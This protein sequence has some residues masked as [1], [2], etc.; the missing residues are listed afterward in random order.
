MKD[1]APPLSRARIRSI[2]LTDALIVAEWLNAAAGTKARTR[3]LAFRTHLEYL[4]K[5]ADS[6]RTGEPEFRL[7]LNEVN[8]RLSRYSFHS[9]LS[10]DSG[11]WRDNAVAKDAR[12]RTVEVT[13]QGVTVEVNEAAAVAAL[14]RLHARGQLG[15]VRMCEWCKENFRVSERELD[16]F[17]SDRCRNADYQARPATVDRKK[18]AQKRWRDKESGENAKALA[19]VRAPLKGRK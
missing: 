15:K 12:G 2:A 14:G 18:K 4:T 17:C 5:M 8:N 10:Y 16:R 7:R 9:L 11:M 3:V 13:H 1:V 19:C 6:G